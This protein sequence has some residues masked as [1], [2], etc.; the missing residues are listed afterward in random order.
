VNAFDYRQA[1][2]AW[3]GISPKAPESFAVV[4]NAIHIIPEGTNICVVISGKDLETLKTLI[5]P[6]KK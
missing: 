2:H 1:K 5:P 4:G 3:R 6:K